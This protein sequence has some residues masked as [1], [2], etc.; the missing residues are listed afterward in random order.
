MN[1]LLLYEV[2]KGPPVPKA[3]LIGC[4]S[5]IFFTKS[6]LMAGSR[7]QLWLFKVDTTTSL[8]SGPDEEVDIEAHL[9]FHQCICLGH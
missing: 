4:V 5:Q 3:V 9:L 2:V 6:E 1:S 8:K 7:S